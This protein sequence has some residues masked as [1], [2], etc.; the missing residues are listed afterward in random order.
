MG[1]G[2]RPGRGGNNKTEGGEGVECC[3]FLSLEKHVSAWGVLHTHTNCP[4]KQASPAFGR[5]LGERAR[6]RRGLGRGVITRL[7][8][9]K[10]MSVVSFCHSKYTKQVSRVLHT[11]TNSALRNRHQPPSTNIGRRDTC[12]R[13]G[14]INKIGQWGGPFPSG[15]G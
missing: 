15:H 13:R 14:G 8:G 2:A 12:A 10:G 5:M 1:E 11:H 9:E 4:A 3:V 6:A 7:K